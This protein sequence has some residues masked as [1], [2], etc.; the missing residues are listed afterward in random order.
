MAEFQFDEEFQPVEPS[1]VD[2]DPVAT[3]RDLYYRVGKLEQSLDEQ[4]V[5]AIADQRDLLLGMVNTADEIARIVERWGV[6][7]KAQEAEMIRGVVGMGR[8]LL[9]ILKRH[10]VEAIDTLGRPLSPETS[11]VVETEARPGLPVN[12]VLREEQIGYRWP[13]GILR[14]AQVVVSSKGDARGVMRDAAA[15]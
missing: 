7:T 9:A 1:V 8:E 2:A 13:H 10:H 11:D 12:T 5:Q 14:R 3:M 6:T 15:H 4:R